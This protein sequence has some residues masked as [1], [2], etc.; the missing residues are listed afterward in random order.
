M[1]VKENIEFIEKFLADGNEYI[2]RRDPV[3]ASEK[4]YKVVEECIKALTEK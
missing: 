2:K 4:L 3:Q 1:N